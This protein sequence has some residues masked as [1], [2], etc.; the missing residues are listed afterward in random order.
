MVRRGS[1][2][3]V[4]LPTVPFRLPLSPRGLYIRMRH[5]ILV[6]VVLVVDDDDAVF[7]VIVFFFSYLLSSMCFSFVSCTYPTYT[8]FCASRHATI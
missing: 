4:F 3:T 7:V 6:D 1:Q 2:E 5:M 8:L